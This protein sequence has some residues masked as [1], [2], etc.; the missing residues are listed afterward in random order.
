MMLQLWSAVA[1]Q[2]KAKAEKRKLDFFIPV[3]YTQ[4]LVLD[5]IS[6]WKEKK[7]LKSGKYLPGFPVG[8]FNRTQMIIYHKEKPG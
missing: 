1:F 4:E 2:S 5:E 8:I 7:V 3:Y 6:V